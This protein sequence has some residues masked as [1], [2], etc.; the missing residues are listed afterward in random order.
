MPRPRTVSDRAILEAAAAVIGDVGPQQLTLAEVGA[1]AGL[2]PATLLQRFGSR[3]QLLLAL[4]E[5]DVDAVP[6]RLRELAGHPPVVPALV[7]TLA[8]LAAPL[9]GPAEFAHH[10]AFLLMDLSDPAFA[11]VTARYSANLVAALTEV[12]ATGRAAGELAEEV[13]VA[14]LAELVHTVYNGALVTWGMTGAGRPADRVHRH[15]TA[16]LAPYRATTA[17]AADGPP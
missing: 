3:R 4:A 6:D 16:F 8:G 14:D 12:L 1:R 17:G 9:T 7:D 2:S 10:L 13:D 11:A 15:L 5:H